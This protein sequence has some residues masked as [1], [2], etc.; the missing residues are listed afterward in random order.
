MINLSNAVRELRSRLDLSVREAAKELGISYVHLSKI[1]NGHTSP[2]PEVID[3][4][5][6]AWGIDLYMFAV[7]NFADPNAFPESVTAPLERLRSAW[8]REIKT[9]IRR[10]R[11]EASTVA[12][13]VYDKANC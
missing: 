7:C 1:E 8:E 13:S 11:R 2:S 6:S 12:E 4:F 10:R 9:I 3:K 5:R